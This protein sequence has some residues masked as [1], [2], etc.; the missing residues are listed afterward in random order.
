MYQLYALAVRSHG[1]IDVSITGQLENTCMGAEVIDKYPHGHRVYIVDPGAA[2]VFIAEK[3][4][5]P[6]PCSE[7]LV[8]W[9]A[10]VQILDGQHKS[11]EIFVNEEKLLTVN[12][13]ESSGR[14]DVYSL[15]GAPGTGCIIVP[16]GGIV[17]AI[18][19]HVFG[20]GSYEEC[21]KYVA[22]NCKKT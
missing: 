13:K 10:H 8:H 9:Q 14:Y 15:T 4:A 12:V 1:R 20:P 16:E 18:Y 19:S 17:L 6:G 22:A 2:Q 3:R 7:V 11:V 21:Q 5:H